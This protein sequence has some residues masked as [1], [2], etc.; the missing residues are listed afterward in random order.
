ML[1]V[2]AV[3]QMLEPGFCF[4]GIAAKRRNKSN[5]W[6]KRGTLLP[7]RGGRAAPA[8]DAARA[9][10]GP[11]RREGRPGYAEEV[12]TWW[13]QSMSRCEKGTA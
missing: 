8:N 1:Q 13:Q 7:E 10:H 2:E 11:D 3:L 5:P 4:A 9:R 6:F 12:K